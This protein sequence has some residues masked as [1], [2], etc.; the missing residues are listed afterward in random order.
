MRA[1]AFGLVI[2]GSGCYLLEPPPPETE[3]RETSPW[4]ELPALRIP[5]ADLA[6][7]IREAIFRQEHQIQDLAEKPARILSDWNLHLEPYPKEGCRTRLEAEIL[8]DEP[9]EFKVRVRAWRQFNDN[10]V[11]PMSQAQ[12]KWKKGGL[13][14]I[15]LKHIDPM[16]FRFF[17]SLRVSLL[18]FSRD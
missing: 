13:D 16:G 5:H 4:L 12:A 1:A 2:L 8:P 9:G 15:H 7:K 14:P 3:D 17:Q 11:D 10:S 6:R 18:A